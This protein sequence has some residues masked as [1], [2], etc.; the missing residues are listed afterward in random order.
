MLRAPSSLS[1]ARCLS[2]HEVG[3]VNGHFIKNNIWFLC[4]AKASLPHTKPVYT[5]N[6]F[7]LIFLG[8]VH[9]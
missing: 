7:T 9:Y 3:N 5:I 2:R 8:T 6:I 4:L 1:G